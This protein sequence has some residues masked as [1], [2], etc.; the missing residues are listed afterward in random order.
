MQARV[1]QAKEETRLKEEV[2][3]YLKCFCASK[4]GEQLPND[5]SFSM[6]CVFTYITVYHRIPASL[7][8]YFY[9]N[10]FE[11]SSTCLRYYFG[12]ANAGITCKVFLLLTDLNQGFSRSSPVFVPIN[13][14]LSA[15]LCHLCHEQDGL[16]LF[17]KGFLSA[18]LS[19]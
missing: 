7:Q 11:W 15:T 13:I 9:L 8:Y 6:S 2:N 5:S 18:D 14:F 3:K 17:Q 10:Q 1:P 19:L 16:S 4:H 12:G